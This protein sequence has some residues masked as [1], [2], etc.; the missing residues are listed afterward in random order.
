MKVR[1]TVQPSGLFNGEP[2]P[3]V[4]DEA[5][6]PD[7]VA[8]DMIE[9]GRAEPVAEKAS[10]KAEKRPAAKREEKRGED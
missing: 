7:V 9:A 6:L 2:W 1:I 5:D 3:A 4:G 8:V 10:D